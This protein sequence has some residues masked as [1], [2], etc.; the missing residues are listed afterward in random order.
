MSVPAV[1]H[2]LAAVVSIVYVFTYEP[3]RGSFNLI[4]LQKRKVFGSVLT[5]DDGSS[6]STSAWKE[7]ITHTPPIFVNPRAIVA[8]NSPFLHVV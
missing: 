5:T 6:P 1:S 8:F 2:L 4:G 7:P 3:C